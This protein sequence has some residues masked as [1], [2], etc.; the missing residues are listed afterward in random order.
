MNP[1]Y[2]LLRDQS[3]PVFNP[4]VTPDPSETERLEAKLREATQRLRQRFEHRVGSRTRMADQ[5]AVQT[6]A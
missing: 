6:T 4:K 3:P 5:G 1:F 2:S